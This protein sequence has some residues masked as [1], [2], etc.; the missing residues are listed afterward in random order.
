[1]NRNLNQLPRPTYRRKYYLKTQYT[2]NEQFYRK[3]L[4]SKGLVSKGNLRNENCVKSRKK[5]TRLTGFSPSTN[6]NN[7]TGY[8]RTREGFICTA[9][10]LIRRKNVNRHG[11][12]KKTSMLN[13]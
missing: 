5:F 2:D 1:M 8:K 11:C 3:F 7:F 13:K 10:N 6:V 4:V 9:L 12:I